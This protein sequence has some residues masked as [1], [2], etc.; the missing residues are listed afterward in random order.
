M[1]ADGIHPIVRALSLAWLVPRR[2]LL[3]RRL[4]RPV[5][6]RVCGHEIRVLP[7]VFNPVVFR[8]GAFF[9]EFLAREYLPS[10]L[11][12]LSILDLGTGSGVLAVVCAAHGHRVT[13]TDVNPKAVECARLNVA[14]H[15]YEPLVDVRDGDL[16]APVAGRRFDLI[17]WN[18]P[19][20]PG[21]PG[22]PFEIA[23]RS[24]DVIDRFAAALSE[25]LNP[26]GTALLAWSS[27]SDTQ[28]LFARLG[29]HGFE[30]ELVRSAH[31]GVERLAIYALRPEAA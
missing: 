26:G 11:K 9:A 7:G 4:S 10:Q 6:E 3:R 8:S 29:A 22:T 12:P 1:R 31:F 28:V 30:P 25:H 21:Q 17:L 24:D 27:Q 14:D 23:W 19:F 15:G 18:P 20:F 13:A 2:A 16:L 5:V